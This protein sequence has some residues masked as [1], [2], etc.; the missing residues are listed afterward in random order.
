[1]LMM[2]LDRTERDE[3]D[4]LHDRLV[5]FGS[6]SGLF[7]D[8]KVKPRARQISDPF[9]LQV[10]VRSGAHANLVDVGYGVSQSLPILVDVMREKRTTFLLQQ[11]EIH[12][13]PRGQAELASLF[14]KSWKSNKNRFLIDTHSDHIVD[15]VR[16]SV[17]QG[18][19]KPN[20]VSILYFEPLQNSV[21]IHNL[22]VDKHG[23]LLDVPESYR[24]F[25]M[26][27]TDRLLGFSDD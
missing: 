3:W 15:R 10:K 19:L 27:E 16:I 11:P 23:N 17:R 2:R 7:S 9:Q 1:M 26:R 25:F 12:L 14:V 8:I 6:E 13:H 20:E 18:I 21:K 4:E 22:R 24:G 5:G